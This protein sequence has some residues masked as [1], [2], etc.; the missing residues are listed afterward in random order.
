MTRRVCAGIPPP[1]PQ[2][3]GGT[4][5]SCKKI[6]WK[7]QSG[8]L[9]LPL[10]FQWKLLVPY[11]GMRFEDYQ[12][13]KDGGAGILA[14]VTCNFIAS[15]TFH[16]VYSGV[17]RAGRVR[18]LSWALIWG[19]KQKKSGCQQRCQKSLLILRLATALGAGCI[20]IPLLVSV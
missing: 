8:L 9:L 10:Y 18:S 20:I 14:N 5:H 6:W 19:G 13:S 4:S 15:N 12:G 7:L 16:S 3:S 17:T 2:N 11:L 1:P